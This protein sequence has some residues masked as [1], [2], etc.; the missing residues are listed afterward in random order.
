MPFKIDK[1]KQRI[2]QNTAVP[3]FGKVKGQVLSTYK[4]NDPVVASVVSKLNADTN[5]IAN[6]QRRQDKN[7]VFDD[8]KLNFASFVSQYQKNAEQMKGNENIYQLFPDM[9]LCV[10]TLSSMVLSPK[11]MLGVAYVVTTKNI[12][13]KY[14]ADVL[15]K[16]TQLV[17]KELEKEYSLK[18][19]LPDIVKDT[20]FI[21]GAVLKVVLP[22]NNLDYHINRDLYVSNE[23]LSAHVIT[24]TNTFRNL[25]FLGQ[26]TATA[27]AIK[28]ITEELRT[29]R[30]VA[31]VE[32]EI[33]FSA[34]AKTGVTITDN[35]NALKMPKLARINQ[36][37]ATEALLIGSV[38]VENLFSKSKANKLTVGDI[39]K[40]NTTVDNTPIDAIDPTK[41]ARPA[42]GRPMV[43]DIPVEAAIPIHVPG[44]PKDYLGFIILLDEMGVP[45]TTAN[46]TKDVHEFKTSSTTDQGVNNFLLEKARSN[47]QTM[48]SGDQENKDLAAI[49]SSYIEKEIVDRLNN[50]NF[51]RSFALGKRDDVYRTML[52]RS[53]AGRRTRMLFVPSEI[54]TYFTHEVYNNGIGKSL[55][56][57]IKV[58][59]SLRGILLFAKVSALTK[60]S[61]A[62][63]NVNMQLDPNDPDPMN[64]IEKA[65]HEVIR[66]RQQYLPIGISSPLDLAE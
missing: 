17:T 65:M 8:S 13:N 32:E 26:K 38:A 29:G 3:N 4:V 51:T 10:Q 54:A 9:E 60:N 42:V 62:I 55:F 64:T 16:I 58:L 63:T 20:L 66:T 28:Y 57:K 19:H 50:G 35:Y 12:S 44:N 21:K 27:S 22:E 36:K 25:G 15:S 43:M 40:V 45:L 2:D 24:K 41:S 14:S 53:L 34:E 59:L 18:E 11:D 33:Q 56:E 39:Y 5:T 46:Y 7:S 1:L 61:I 47:L 37:I 6:Q 23:D 48:N 49:Y 31:S 52:Y 30:N